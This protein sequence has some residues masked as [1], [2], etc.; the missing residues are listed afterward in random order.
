MFLEKSQHGLTR[1][2]SKPPH[3]V[4]NISHVCRAICIAVKLVSTTASYTQRGMFHTGIMGVGGEG[5]GCHHILLQCSIS[6]G[7]SPNS[8]TRGNNPTTNVFSSLL[9][10]HGLYDIFT[11]GVLQYHLKEEEVCE[12]VECCMQSDLA[13]IFS[14]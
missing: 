4:S 8:H 1:L 10:V 13:F 14:L 9:K 3:Y 6:P 11:R 7:L 5:G 2:D 12:I